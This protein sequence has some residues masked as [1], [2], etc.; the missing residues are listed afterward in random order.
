MPAKSTRQRTTQKLT[1]PYYAALPTST[2]LGSSSSLSPPSPSS[3]AVLLPKVDDDAPS[4]VGNG[5]YDDYGNYNYYSDP[6]QSDLSIPEAL[7]KHDLS[8][9]AALLAETGVQQRLVLGE[10]LQ[11]FTLFAPSDKAWTDFFDLERRF[12]LRC[13]G[14][15]TCGGAAACDSA[16]SASSRS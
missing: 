7:D 3:N 10:G 16:T 9:M 14:V 11:R 12:G 6:T 1:S 15:H 13:F 4:A 8:V 5:V 2:T